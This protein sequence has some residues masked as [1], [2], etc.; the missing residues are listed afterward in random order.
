ML[1]DYVV[2]ALVFA[3]LAGR[4]SAWDAALKEFNVKDSVFLQEIEDRTNDKGWAKGELAGKIQSGR[5][6]PPEPQVDLK[7]FTRELLQSIPPPPKEGG[8]WEDFD[9]SKALKAQ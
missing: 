8:K 1:A 3:E 4:K 9:A 2:I 6:K 5:N 7:P